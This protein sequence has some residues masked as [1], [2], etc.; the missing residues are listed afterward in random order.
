MPVLNSNKKLLKV[1][2][3][4]VSSPPPFW[5]MRQAGRYMPEYRALREKAGSFLNLC[6]NPEYAAE[7]TLQPIRAFDMDAAILFAD[8]LLIPAALGVDL[9][10]ETG[11]GPVLGKFSPDELNFDESKLAPV[12]ETLKILKRELP[13]DKTLIGFA[14]SPWTVATY[15]VEGGSSKNFAKVKRMAICEPEYFAQLIDVIV[16]STIKYLS[17]QIKAGAEV[18]QLFD[19]WAGELSEEEFEKW[20]TKPT[21]KITSALKKLHPEIKIIGFPRRAHFSLIEYANISAVDAVSLDSTSRL[22]WAFENMKCVIQGNLDPAI[23]FSDKDCIKR[24]A[25]KI[26]NTA[27]GKPFIFNLGHGILPETPVE[28]VKYLSELIRNFK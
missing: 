5:F 3:G 25:T 26:L 14:G 6:F 17:S 11:E 19:S 22:D 16:D 10:F 18:V 21:A 12:Y 15:M 4:E 27:K 9:K 23:L 2:N 28:N 7:V 1:L 8:I 13:K 20:V 24:E